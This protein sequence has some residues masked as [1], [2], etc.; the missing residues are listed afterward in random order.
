MLVKDNQP[1]LR[2][3]IE[4]LLE[5]ATAGAASAGLTRQRVRVLGD[6][7]AL[8]RVRCAQTWNLGHGRIEWRQLQ[9]LS[10]P[11]WGDWQAWPECAQV[12]AVRRQSTFKKSGHKRGE[13]VYGI[14]NLGVGHASAE[15]L[16][17]LCRGHWGIENRSHWVRDVTFDEDRSTVRC[18]S[19]PQIMAALRNTVIGLM[20]LAGHTNIAAACR[21]HAARPHEVLTLLG[22]HSTFE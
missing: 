8:P 10:V 22:F 3:D 7:T 13:T 15:Q 16:L 19:V 5:R 20:R 6:D 21:R 1:T 2:Q 17:A 18:G 12:F 11:A 14:T 9:A 4:R